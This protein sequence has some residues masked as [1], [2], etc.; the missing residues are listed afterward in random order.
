MWIK[1]MLQQKKKTDLVYLEIFWSGESM[2]AAENM[3]M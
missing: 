3:C 1:P 2:G